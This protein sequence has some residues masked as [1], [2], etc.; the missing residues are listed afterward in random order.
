MLKGVKTVEAYIRAAP[1]KFRG[2]LRQM[3]AAIRKAAPKALEKISYR[4]PHYDYK[5]RLVYFALARTHIGLY[6]PPP[7]LQNHQKELKSYSISASATVR[8]PLDQ[9]L[10]LA[11][12][13][14]LVKAR[15]HYNEMKKRG[16][17][18]C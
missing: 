14:K 17:D 3:Q 5:G 6:I 15:V 10:P 9:E 7:I 4:M 13:R 2:M 8:F 16:N 12:I 18:Q 11:L 1:P